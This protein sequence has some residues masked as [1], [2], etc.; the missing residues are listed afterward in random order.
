MS[1][2]TT[3]RIS[4]TQR[5]ERIAE[6]FRGAGQ[7][8]ANAHAAVIRAT[9]PAAVPVAPRRDEPGNLG[10]GRFRFAPPAVPGRAGGAPSEFS[11][12]HRALAEGEPIPPAPDLLEQIRGLSRLLARRPLSLQEEEAL[13]GE[14]EP[15]RPANGLGGTA[16]DIEAEDEALA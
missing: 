6:A 12:L 9:A 5:M 2:N 11:H 7:A 1:A 8:A 15:Q 16:A 4:R 10:Q 14:D 3:R 13:R